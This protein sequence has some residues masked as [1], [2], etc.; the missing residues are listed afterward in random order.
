MEHVA[1]TSKEVGALE[2]WIVSARFGTDALMDGPVLGLTS[3]GAVV[4]AFT[5]GTVL[6]RFRVRGFGAGAHFAGL[7]R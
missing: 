2:S 7:G 1:A 6:Q 4:H 3:A 5:F